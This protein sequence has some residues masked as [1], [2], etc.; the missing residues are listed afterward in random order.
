[1]FLNSPGIT[2]QEVD[3]TAGVQNVATTDGAFA[4]AFKWGPCE[5][6]TLIESEEQLVER[7]GKPD[8]NTAEYF[9]TVKNF[10]DYGGKARI[11]RTLDNDVALNATSDYGLA[12]GTVTVNSSANV[13]TG[14]GTAFNTEFHV[15]QTIR[16]G[17][18]G[19]VLT[20]GSI[21]NATHMTATSVPSTNASANTLYY[22]GLYIKNG[23]VYENSYSSGEWNGGSWAAK[24]PGVLGNSLKV[25]MAGSANAFSSTPSGTIS[26]ANTTTTTVTGSST[27]FTTQVNVGDILTVYGQE[28]EVTAIT[29]TTQL[30]VN[31]AFANAFTANAFTREWAYASLFD[32]APGTSAFANARGGSADELH[33]VVVDEDGLWTGV[34]K[35]VL[36]RFAFVS[37]AADAKQDNG[38]NSY[39]KEVLNRN[40]KYV[41]W[42][43]HP[44]NGTNWGSNAVGVTFD[45]PYLVSGTSL[46]GALDG[47][48]GI[49]AADLTRG[50]DLFANKE[51]VDVSLVIAPPC[52]NSSIANTVANHLVSNIAES[53]LDC[54]VFLSP[55][56]NLVVN[57]AGNESANLVSYRAGLPSSSYAVMDSG[58]KYQLDRYNDVYRWIPLCGDT[59]GLCARTDRQADPWFSPAGQARG[60][61]K[62]VVKLAWNP[63]QSERDDLYKAGINAIV[64]LSG[65]GT[66]LWGDKTMLTRPSAFDRINVRR[67]FIVLEKAISRAG[68]TALFEFNDEFTRAQFVNIVEPFLRDVKARRG[69]Q[70]FKVICDE[71]NNT[72]Q[73]I[74]AQ[75]FRGD[76]YIKPARSINF[77]T[78]RF[79]AVRSGVRFEELVPS[80]TEI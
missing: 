49:S 65:Q 32:A 67:L 39:Y 33:V 10:L 58:W 71:S 23:T 64:Q 28:R 17:A 80:V 20:I 53:R 47:T 26:V 69:I 56:K 40:S 1:M 61:V 63:R 24:Y 50:Y 78:L 35:T 79:V 42:M 74:D 73:V 14:S 36:E 15:G 3:V 34:P 45:A 38:E 21:T 25:S 68:Q 55:P 76:I 44:S 60:N 8:A 75:E 7:F 5:E 27:S 41:W 72:A 11:V 43:D 57:N 9:F 16:I 6:V 22:A 62:N 54:V 66:V 29:N 51:D 19:D 37:K 31:A 52:A 12:T 18:S 59:A 48:S 4:G 13:V 46:F 2:V 77:I 30:T 70:E